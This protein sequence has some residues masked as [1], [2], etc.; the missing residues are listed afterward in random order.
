MALVPLAQAQGAASDDLAV[1]QPTEDSSIDIE[2]IRREFAE[3]KLQEAQSKGPAPAQVNVNDSSSG[4]AASAKQAS[5]TVSPQ[6]S[7]ISK[8]LSKENERLLSAEQDLLAELQKSSEVAGLV[9]GDTQPSD[10]AKP[11]QA[12]AADSLGAATEVSSGPRPTAVSSKPITSTATALQATNSDTVV[13]ARGRVDLEKIRARA[14]SRASSTSEQATPAD[15]ANNNSTY[16]SVVAASSPISVASSPN[17]DI[18]LEDAF[19]GALPEK[20]SP[21]KQNSGSEPVRRASIN[22]APNNQEYRSLSAKVAAL[23]ADKSRLKQELSTA[24]NRLMVAETEVER[25]ASIVEKRNQREV[26]RMTGSGYA[27]APSTVSYKSTPPSK[28]SASKNSSS[29]SSYTA[30]QR[31][32]YSRNQPTATRVVSIQPPA[33]PDMPVATV[34]ADKANL[35]IGPS[36]NDAPLMSISKGARLVVEHREAGWYRVIAPTGARAWVS[37]DVVSFGRD[38]LSSPTETLQIKGYDNSLEP[39]GYKVTETAVQ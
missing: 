1:H 3:I 7:G 37:S 22:Q 31:D 39:E 34:T 26:V 30:E 28:S 15:P 27:S 10:S 8:S 9:S 6:G 13:D 20:V 11:L 18:E 38:Y 35:R 5:G 21:T 17:A 2:Q 16:E 12:K 29:R 25:L 14:V 33:A 36:T 19:D 4:S 24:R 23:E 32:G